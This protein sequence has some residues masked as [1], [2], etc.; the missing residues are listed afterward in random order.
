MGVDR[1]PSFRIL[2]MTRVR[3]S[4]FIC[5]ALSRMGDR[6]RPASFKGLC[7]SSMGKLERR[8]RACLIALL[9]IL[10]MVVRCLSLNTPRCVAWYLD[11]SSCSKANDLRGGISLRFA[12]A[13]ASFEPSLVMRRKCS[14]ESNME[15]MWTPG[16]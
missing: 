7:T 16:I 14:R 9:R 13:L 3:C 2:F 11:F 10:S 15:L 12:R 1:E 5:V 8:P 4:I 6:P